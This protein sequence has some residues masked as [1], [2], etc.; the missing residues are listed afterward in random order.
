VLSQTVLLN[1]NAEPVP[2]AAP[3]TWGRAKALAGL[4]MAQMPFDVLDGNGLGFACKGTVAVSPLSPYPFKTLFHEMVHLVLGHT[5]EN[6]RGEGSTGLEP[7]DGRDLS[8]HQWAR[9]TSAI[10]TEDL[11]W[12]NQF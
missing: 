10:E 5:T 1:E 4:D 9:C 3:L 2:A 8:S 12:D 7:S 6:F 11:R